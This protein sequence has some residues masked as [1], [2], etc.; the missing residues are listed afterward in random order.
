MAA[1]LAFGPGA[2]LSHRNA[3]ELWGLLPIRARL[4]A[5]TVPDRNGRI[6]GAGFS[7]I[8]LPHCGR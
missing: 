3:A 6:N 7:S 8:A 2:A 5:V 1:V 4:I